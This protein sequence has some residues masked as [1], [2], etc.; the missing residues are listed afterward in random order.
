[1]RR[2]EHQSHLN[3]FLNRQTHGQRPV[4]FHALDFGDLAVLGQHPQFFEHFIELLFVGHGKNFLRLDLA[5]MELDAPVSQARHH[6]IVRDHHDRPPLLVKLAQQPQHNL[7]VDRVE[8]ACR[9]IRQNNLRI[10]D[11]RPRNAH[12]LLFAAGKL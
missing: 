3:H 4:H 6:G 5:M 1:M 9:L 12:P 11:Q 8:V 10:I 7:F 2:G